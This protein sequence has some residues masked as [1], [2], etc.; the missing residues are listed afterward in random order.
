VS[1]IVRIIN[2]H[3]FLTMMCGVEDYWMSVICRLLLFR[4]SKPATEVSS[5]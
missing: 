3:M 2:I 1:V 4:A 5:Y